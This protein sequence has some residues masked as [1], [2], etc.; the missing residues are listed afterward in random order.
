MNE[1]KPKN[2]IMNKIQGHYFIDVIFKVI[3]YF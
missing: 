2:Q 1:Y 3:R